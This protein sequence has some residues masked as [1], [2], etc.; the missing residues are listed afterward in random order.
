VRV[1]AQDLGGAFRSID[2]P[3]SVFENRDDIVA[4][5]LL[6]VLALHDTRQLAIRGPGQRG[7]P[8]GSA[9]RVVA[10]ARLS[11]A[12]KRLAAS[13]AEG[14]VLQ[15]HRRARGH[16]LS[17]LLAIILHNQRLCGATTD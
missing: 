17:P 16:A 11:R 6:Q 1:D 9:S 12:L 8:E 7:R 4:L 13:F 14:R 3:A 5:H 2:F 15:L 10:W